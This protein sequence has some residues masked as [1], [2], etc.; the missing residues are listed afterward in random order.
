TTALREGGEGTTVLVINHP[1]LYLAV[2]RDPAALKLSD[3]DVL[4]ADLRDPRTIVVKNESDLKSF[5]DMVERAKPQPGKVSVSVTAAG[6]QEVF[7][8][9]LFPALKLDVTV[10]GYRGGSDAAQALMAND[11]T[12]TVGDDYSRLNMRD[13]AR[14]LLIGAHERSS[15]WPEAP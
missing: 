2:Q 11:V 6:G 7:A 15:R 10:A 3:F 12:A 1:D 14:A 4:M 8:K 5:A 13:Q 9:W